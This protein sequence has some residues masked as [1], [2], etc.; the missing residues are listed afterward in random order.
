MESLGYLSDDRKPLTT[1][2]I[3]RRKLLAD[4]PWIYVAVAIRKLDS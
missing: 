2:R 3:V 4:C 1:V